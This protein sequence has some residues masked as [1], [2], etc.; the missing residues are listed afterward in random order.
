MPH[1]PVLRRH[2]H[3]LWSSVH[4][5]RPGE[6]AKRY[7]G[8]GWQP[9]PAPLRGKIPRGAWKH[10]QSERVTERDIEDGFSR[11]ANVFLICGAISRL[12]VLDCDDEA[13][14]GYWREKLGQELLD[15]TTAV[16]TGNGFH[17]YFRLREGQIERGRAS[18]GGESGKWDIRAEGGGVIAPPSIHPSGRIYEWLRD[19]SHLQDAP[20]GL[21]D[22]V[23]SEGVAGNTRSML[24][25]LLQTGPTEGNRNQWLARI[26]GHY[27]KHIPHQ[28]AYEQMVRDANGSMESPLPDEEVDKL[29]PSIWDAEQAKLGKAIPE[30]DEEGSDAWRRNLMSASEETGWLVSGGN[31]IAVETVRKGEEGEM[32]YGLAPWL[33]CDI[34]VLGVIESD[35]DLVYSVEIR[36]R[37][38]GVMFEDHVSSATLADSRSMNAWLARHRASI[39]PPNSLSQRSVTSSTRLLRYLE[40]QGAQPMEAAEAL[41]WHEESDAFITHEGIIRASGPSIFENVRPDPTIKGWAPYSYGHEM[42]CDEARRILSEVMTFHD[43]VVTAIFGAWWAACLLKPQI[44]NRASQFPFMAIEASSESGKTK[45]YFPLMNQLAGSQAGQINPTKAALRD[46]LS[47]N[48][49]GIVWVDDLDDLVHLGEILRQVTVGGSLA[50]KGNENHDQVVAK[51]R[52]ALV[53]SG[54]SLGLQDQKALVDRAIHLKVDSP[55][56]RKSVKGDYPQ[57]DDIVSLTRAYPDLTIFAGSIVELALQQADICHDLKSLRVGAGR[58]ADTMAILRVGARAL[59]EILGGRPDVIETVD[60]WAISE[61]EQYTGKENVLTLKLL[62]RALRRTD[63]MTKPNGPSGDVGATPAIVQKDESDNESVWFSPTLLAEWWE[64]EAPARRG[65]DQ[66]TSTI[67][68][69]EGQARALGMGGRKGAT[70]DRKP[71]RFADGNG[72]A[73]YWKCTPGISELV[74]RRSRGEEEIDD[75]QNTDADVLPL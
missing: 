54:E 71:I 52:S 4:V 17:F 50:K 19:P 75:D 24:T 53:V 62:P 21:F 61:S 68:A 40:A 37:K 36:L 63:W 34:R 66:R 56:G 60:A 47:A 12:A 59:S 55:L 9:V 3:R 1:V 25:H 58:H 16:R 39:T 5:V 48:N 45:G 44:Q 49:N 29:I 2:R 65:V 15:S 31:H 74:L 35:H 64:R 11:S 46:Y 28:D 20:P 18:D 33:N 32:I 51:M 8:I 67:K 57:W 6:A 69:L 72:K 23:S 13:A 10:R 14:L 70:G 41:G 43:S 30:L 22:R 7:L 42:G 26:A 38:E 73:I 27:A